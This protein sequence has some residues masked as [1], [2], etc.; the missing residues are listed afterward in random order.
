MGGESS[1]RESTPA[2]AVF[3]SY[4]SQDAEAARRICDALRAAGIEVWFDQSMLRGGDAWDRKIRQQIRDCALFVPIVSQNTQ[5]RLE[6]YFRLEWKLAVDRSH[7]MAIERPF[8]VPVV[9]DGTRDQEAVVPDAFR[10]VQWTRVPAGDP[11]PAFVDHVRRLLSPEL[12]RGTT[13]IRPPA[14]AGSGTAAVIGQSVR[15]SWRLRPALLALV[16]VA[17]SGALAYFVIDK[18]WIPK[19][20]PTSQPITSAAPEAASRARTTPAAFAPPPHSIAVLPFVN[21]SGDKEQDYFSDG[22]SEELLNSLA[23]INELQVAART[24]SFYFKGEHADLPTIAHKLNV[25]S[26]LEG[27]VRRSGHT[28]RITAQLNNAVT[29]YHLWSQTYD[30]DLGDVLKLQTDIANAVA[31]ALRVTLLG[32]VAAK[33]EVGGTRNPAAF[34]A[35]L[36]ASNAYRRFGPAN[37]AAGGLNEEGLQSAIAAYTEAIHADPDYALAYA[38]R[39]L[40]FADFA[41]ALVKG[42]EVG[43]YFNKAQLDAHKAIAL[44]P[45]LADSHLALANF[46][47]GS[48]EPTGALQEYELALALAPGDARVLREYGAFAVLIGRTE[49]GLAAAHRLLVLDPLNSTNHFGLGVSLTFA[50][51][52]GDAIRAFRDAKALGQ[53]DVSVNMWLGIAY[54]LSGDF[55][56]A[57]AACER[58][59]EVNGPWCLAMIY[60]KLGRHTEAETM[61][62]KVRTIAGDRFAEGYAD[63]YAQW[64]DTARALDWLETAM[65]NRDPYL[66]YTK[67]NPFF[68]PLRKES[69]FQAIERALKFPN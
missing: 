68:D 41:R 47:A 10:A 42:P 26:V 39:S 32:D 57:R 21:M 54:Y 65:R 30:R 31:N 64:G 67:V 33:I 4:A 34:D 2:A 48:L 7:L 63:I 17:V 29:G 27:S 37:L 46:F 38:G 60:D 36:R 19:H 18:I 8:L 5:E 59:G 55:Q 52:Y 3:L 56:S 12:F 58:A 22:L 15:A 53:D 69:R 14:S 51:R 61:L 66:A 45:D 16:A 50:R 13:T 9:V 11:P 43:D 6:G 62:A 24:S 35:Y 44:T 1:N 20:S 40:T 23:R 28:I 49:A 25:A